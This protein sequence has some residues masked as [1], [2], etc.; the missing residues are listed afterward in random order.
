MKT[1]CAEDDF[2]IAATALEHPHI[3]GQCDR[4]IAAGADL[5][6]VYDDDP[7]K[8]EAFCARYPAVRKHFSPT[9]MLSRIHW[10]SPPKK[11]ATPMA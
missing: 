3:Y 9:M 6:W 1:V 7:E 10:N 8:M 4:L 2:P 5:R 11:A